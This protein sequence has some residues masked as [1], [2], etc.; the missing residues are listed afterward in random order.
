MDRN[1]TVLVTG[2]GGFIGGRI[3]ERLCL[4]GLTQVRAGIR[5]W[6]SAARIARFPVEIV[7]LNVLDKDNLPRLMEGADFV[8]HCAY[9]NKRVNEEGTEN[10][11]QAAL[12]VGV[13]RLVHLS[14]VE[15][16]GN[17]SG[18]VD[19]SR[20]L[21][22]SRNAYADSKINAEKLCIKYLEKGLSVVIL[23]PTV[24]YGPFSKLWTIRLAERLLSGKWGKIN[25]IDGLCN[26]VYVDDLVS[27]IILALNREAVGGEAFNIASSEVLTWNEYFE[28]FN[29]AL[30][31]P[32]VEQKTL[33][34][35]YTRAAF[36]APLRLIAK[37]AMAT[38]SDIIMKASARWYPVKSFAKKI[39]ALIKT[40]PSMQELKLYRRKAV[41]SIEKAQKI[42]GYSP[43]FDL[44]RG[45]QL[46]AAWLKHHGFLQCTGGN[47]CV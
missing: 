40:S 28:R 26:P 12:E 25:H 13:R 43:A 22:Y 9:G 6:S 30:G 17:V 14:T 11:L 24:V 7:Q 46:T 45:L 15:V 16:Y 33:I 23:R 47:S 18:Q 35:S 20:P 32:P 39:E 34:S 36:I 19:E 2:A 41:Y 44:A 21:V 31:L 38:H 1:K 5:R 42:L 4:E 10:V 37:R 29:T 8:V 27:A 3:V